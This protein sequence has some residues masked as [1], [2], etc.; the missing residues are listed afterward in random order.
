M[1][2]I[3]IKEVT[4]ESGDELDYLEL[5][6]ACLK[7]PAPGGYSVEDMEVRLKAL[8]EFP[9]TKREAGKPKQAPVVK[10]VPVSEEVYQELLKCVSNF[11]WGVIDQ[12]F[13]DFTRYIQGIK[14]ECPV[15]CVD[16]GK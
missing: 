14:A 13:V 7:S 3:K 16:D 10:E 11:R 12:V 5:C 2:I 4:T 9:V 15:E 6:N 8:A 1:R